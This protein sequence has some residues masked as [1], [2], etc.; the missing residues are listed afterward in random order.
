MSIQVARSGFGKHSLIGSFLLL[1][2]ALALGGCMSGA[3]A[4][5]EAGEPDVGKQASALAVN[6][7]DSEYLDCANCVGAD[8]V[9]CLERW[10]HG[11]QDVPYP[12]T[13]DGSGVGPTSCIPSCKAACLTDRRACLKKCGTNNACKLDCLTPAECTELCCG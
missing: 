5:E 2:G 9:G 11:C 3:P 13:G 12:G 6:C 7:L 1:C 8:C 4:D 10:S